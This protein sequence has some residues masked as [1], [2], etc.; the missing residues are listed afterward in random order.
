MRKVAFTCT[1]LFSAILVAPNIAVA[2]GAGAPSGGGEY[3]HAISSG[4]TE[5]VTR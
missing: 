5:E 1:L 3:D 4:A 2:A